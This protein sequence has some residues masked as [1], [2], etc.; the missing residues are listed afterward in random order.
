MNRQSCIHLAVILLVALS[1]CTGPTDP[2]PKLGTSI[3]CVLIANDPLA[4]VRLYRTTGL[5][6]RSYDPYD[7]FNSYLVADATIGITIADRVN[8]LPFVA[9]TTFIIFDSLSRKMQIERYYSSKEIA[10]RPGSAYKINVHTHDGVISGEAVLPGDFQISSP[11]RNAVVT[12]KDNTIVI[13][14]SWTSASNA[15][16]YRVSATLFYQWPQRYSHSIT[17]S[18]FTTE[19]EYSAVINIQTI[20]ASLDSV[21]ISVTALDMH[22]YDH[23]VL[24]QDHAGVEGAY[25]VVGG[26]VMHSSA[27]LIKQ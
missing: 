9:D 14:V 27:V 4:R 15:K 10:V 13:P 5:E 7:P 17:E 11:V 25:G 12:L 20:Y 3:D 23:A 24:H 21:V 26:G 19:T 18:Y 1:S 6:D 22:F 8:R 16:L 2:G